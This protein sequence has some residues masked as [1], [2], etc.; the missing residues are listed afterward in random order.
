MN[1]QCKAVSA[2]EAR[3]QVIVPCYNEQEVLEE[4]SRQLDELLSRLISAGKI[5]SGSQIV[6]ID[7]G[8]RDATWSLIEQEARTR[9]RVAGIKLSRNRGHQNAVLAGIMV[10]DAD[11]VVTID[12]DLQDDLNAIE[13]M[14]DQYRCGYEIVYGV[15][16]NRSCDTLFKRNTALLFYRTLALFGVDLVHNHADFR[17]MSRRAVEALREFKEVNLYLRGIVPLIG[18]PST[19]VKYARKERFAGSSKY[20]LRKMLTL[21]IDGITSFSTV[22]L[23]M[24]TIAGFV[25]FLGTL[26]IS[27]WVLWVSFFT[28]RAVPGW[29]STVLPITMLGGLQILCL[30]IIGAYIGKMYSEVKGR[31]RFFIEQI[32]QHETVTVSPPFE[33]DRAEQPHL[34][35]RA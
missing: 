10:A 32:A 35:L 21:A 8:S 16:D 27:A 28:N 25:V 26:L 11:A 20:P 13:E 22:P 17:L 6:F 15:R 24:I 31:P 5:A 30:G 3:I 23:R 19:S 34:G 7:D 14:I 1:K 9:E 4:S 29:A 2:H 33:R 12:A 18:F